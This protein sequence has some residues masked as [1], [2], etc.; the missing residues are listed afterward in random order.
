MAY[1]RPTRSSEPKVARIPSP[2]LN[3]PTASIPHIPLQRWT[4]MAST[5]SSILK[6]T[7]AL[8]VNMYTQPATAPITMAPHNSMVP[9]PAVTATSP[10][11]APFIA[12]GSSKASSPLC[13][14]MIAP[15]KRDMT[16]PTAAAKVVLT[17][18]RAARAPESSAPGN[19]RDE[20]PLKPYPL[21]GVSCNALLRYLVHL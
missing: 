11:S 4:G 19:K 21:K 9:H 8:D 2:L 17:A 13:P 10:P 7:K 14:F 5:A 1:T 15:V 18:V 12:N 16:A 6:R 3:R 20:A